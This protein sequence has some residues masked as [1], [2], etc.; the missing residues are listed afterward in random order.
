MARIEP[1]GGAEAVS[2]YVSKY[3]LKS[4]GEVVLE[5]TGDDR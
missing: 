3:V 4:D 5:V 1:V 2:L